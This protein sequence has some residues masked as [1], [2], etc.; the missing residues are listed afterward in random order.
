M[1]NKTNTTKQTSK[2]KQL[3][4]NLDNNMQQITATGKM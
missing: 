4:F 2:I 3:L 1:F